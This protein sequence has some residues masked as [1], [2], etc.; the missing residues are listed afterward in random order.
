MLDVLEPFFC[1]AELPFLE[2]AADKDKTLFLGFAQRLQAR[3]LG[4]RL[5]AQADGAVQQYHYLD[6]LISPWLVRKR[7]VIALRISRRNDRR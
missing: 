5:P 6:N 4:G 1:Q 2:F 3:A 7:A